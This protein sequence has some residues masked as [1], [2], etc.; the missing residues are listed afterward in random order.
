[1]GK[2]HFHL[3]ARTMCLAGLWCGD[4]A[5]IA[6]W[7]WTDGTVFPQGGLSGSRFA[8]YF[9]VMTAIFFPLFWPLEFLGRIR[10]IVQNYWANGVIMVALGI[11]PFLAL[12][13]VLT[14]F[15][16][17]ISG[18]FFIIAAVRGEPSETLESLAGNGGGPRPE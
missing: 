17:V 13:G 12:P 5:S 9:Y 10:I 3:W 6:L 2:L 14:G 16:F 7:F 1:M 15:C 18:V 8:I 4:L 11:F